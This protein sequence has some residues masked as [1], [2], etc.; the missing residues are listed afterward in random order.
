LIW[1]RGIPK[2]PRI[3]LKIKKNTKEITINP[4]PPNMQRRICFVVSF[5]LWL[6]LRIINT[7]PAGTPSISQNKPMMLDIIRI[8]DMIALTISIVSAYV[9]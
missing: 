4:S 3:T 7:S 5:T 6:A 9:F 8:K 2:N 1:L